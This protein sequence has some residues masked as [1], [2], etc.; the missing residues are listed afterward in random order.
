MVLQLV[1]VGI[2]PEYPRHLENFLR[3]VGLVSL[4]ENALIPA[5]PDR[6]SDPELRQRK[7]SESRA[8]KGNPHHVLVGRVH[9]RRLHQ[10]AAVL[11]AVVVFG[12]FVQDVYPGVSPLAVELFPHHA[13]QGLVEPLHD[14]GLFVGPR[15]EVVYVMTL[16]K[17]PDADVVKLFPFVKLDGVWILAKPL[18]EL[19]QQQVDGLRHVLAVLP[20]DGD[21]KGVSAQ[22]LDGR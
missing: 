22:N 20:V 11:G 9:V 2:S 18:F 15:G 10:R 6:V 3:E 5:H 16:Q 19:F 1:H 7:L 17:I 8:V 21:R 12:E 13:L 14:G 4:T